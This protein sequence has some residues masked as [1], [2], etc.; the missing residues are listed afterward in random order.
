MSFYIG[1]DVGKKGA[2][3]VLKD[4]KVERVVK[5]PDSLRDVYSFFADV[6][7]VAK[8][9]GCTPVAVLEKV[10]PM[11]KQGVTSMF[12]FG[13]GFGALKM[14]AVASGCKLVLV[15]PQEWKK[16]IL[17]GT[18]KSKDAAIRTCEFHFPEVSLVLPGC[19]KP[20]DGMAEAV[21]IA[22]YGRR[23]NI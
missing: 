20:H 22:E 12:T 3:A 5:M 19:R 15:R 8:K 4:K 7:T 17:N 9:S 6:V 13:E 1:I 11:P 16:S 14:A 10:G 21:L 2:L 18:D 23:H